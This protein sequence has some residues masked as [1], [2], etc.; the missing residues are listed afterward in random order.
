MKYIKH[1]SSKLLE[2]VLSNKFIESIDDKAFVVISNNGEPDYYTRSYLEKRIQVYTHNLFK[3]WY[4]YFIIGRTFYF[5][6]RIQI[7][8]QDGK[9][10]HT[11]C[12]V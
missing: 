11:R 4:D 9:I 8:R 2:Y 1:N 7:G 12:R 3:A 5:T 10:G 6:S